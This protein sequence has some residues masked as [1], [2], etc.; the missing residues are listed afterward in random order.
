MEAPASAHRTVIRYV[1]VQCPVWS[2]HSEDLRSAFRRGRETCAERR[3]RGKLAGVSAGRCYRPNFPNALC[4]ESEYNVEPL[5]YGQ[6]IGAE[7]PS[8]PAPDIK[9]MDL[10]RTQILSAALAV[11]ICNSG[12][13]RLFAETEGPLQY[14]APEKVTMLKIKSLTE[15]SGLAASR[16]ESN[17]LWSHND[18]GDGA[19]LYAFDT[20][21]KVLGV[22]DVNGAQARDWEDMASYTWNGQPYLLIADTGDN[23]RKRNEY[24]LYRIPERDPD[25]GPLQV[26]QTVTFKFE[27]GPSDCE[28]MA[29]DTEL[30]QV[31][32][33]DKG[34]SLSCRVFTLDWPEQA[35]SKA[36]IA[37][38]VAVLSLAGVTGMDI[39]P[40][41]RRA[42]VTTYGP[43]YEY[44]RKAGE[45]W[46]SAFART[47]RQIDMPVRRQ[48][49]AIC[50][51]A[52]GKDIF[53]TSEKRPT[54]LFRV[55]VVN[56]S[57][58][59][60]R[61]KNAKDKKTSVVP[62]AAQPSK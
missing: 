50:Y 17:R 62:I 31:I 26:D 5:V 29:F 57:N 59:A 47:G 60:Q 56:E 48:G 36:L 35:T 39:S 32:L 52:N 18:S 21:G 53:L 4:G 14:A 58:S 23:S 22:C 10:R 1:G 43:A 16:I 45:T 27:T 20:S 11:A 25:K 42:I 51:A 55:A 33:I 41:G 38:Q 19:R 34:W 3:A 2:R 13:H 54:P 8:P 44:H 7:S 40:D 49:E 28:S 9:T 46:K 37:K 6:R 12:V 24:K 61:A 30:N 15:S